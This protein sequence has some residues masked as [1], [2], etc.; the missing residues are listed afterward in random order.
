M[1]KKQTVWLLTL[2]SLMIVLSVYYMNSPD[3]DDFSFIFQEEIDGEAEL[4]SNDSLEKE[5]DLT[6][7]SDDNEIEDDELDNDIGDSGI[8][9][10]SSDEELFTTIRMELAQARSSQIEQLESVVASSTATSEEKNKAFEEM[11]KIDQLSTKELIVEESLKAEYDYPD[12]LVRTTDDNVI[13]TIKTDSLS[14]KE[15]N[16]IM[17]TVYDE[18]GSMQVQVKFQPSNT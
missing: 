15:A 3:A 18:F 7:S 17:R 14:E 10:V 5:D 8:S 2:L 1:L 4:A 12:V 16:Q 11:K 9:S 6:L 13:V